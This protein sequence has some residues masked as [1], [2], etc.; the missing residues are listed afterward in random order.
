MLRHCRIFRGMECALVTVIET[1]AFARR[2][3]KLL[4]PDERGE[5]ISFLAENPEAGDE[6]PGTGGVRKVRF[7]A[8]GKGKSGGVRVIYYYFDQSTPL[9]AVFIYGK[10]EQANLTP[11]QK[12]AVSTFA[13]GIKATAKARRTE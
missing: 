5:V 8:K 10:G 13:A 1:T 11:D 3:E 7:A 4:S 9:Y 2:A 6:V 12:R